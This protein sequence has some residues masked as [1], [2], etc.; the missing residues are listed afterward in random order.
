VLDAP[1]LADDFY[2][3]LVD[4]SSTNVLGV[5]LGSCVYLWTAHNASVSKLCD[6]T[7]SNDTISSVSWVQKGSTL[8]VGT[9]AGRLHIYDANTLQLQ[10]TNDG[11]AGTATLASGGN[12]NN[13]C[14]WDLRGSGRPGAGG[15]RGAPIAGGEDNIPNDV[16]V[17]K[18]H[19]HTA[20]VKALAWDPHVWGIL[21]TGGGTQDKHIRF[22]NVI[23][24]TML[25]ELD[26]GSQV[27]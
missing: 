6:L 21:A 4:W 27:S 3:N 22:W 20:A 2:L 1:E 9:L 25:Q 19:E 15:S 23:N 12:D 16:P 5:G 14:I 8:A 13:V 17:W 10:R 24:G 11:G 18:F 26:M 7:P